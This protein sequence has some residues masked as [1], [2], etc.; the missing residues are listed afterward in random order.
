MLRMCA[1]GGQI[2]LEVVALLDE[3]LLVVGATVAGAL[4]DGAVDHVAQVALERDGLREGTSTNNVSRHGSKTTAMAWY[5]AV[6][7]TRHRYVPGG[8]PEYPV[9]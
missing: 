4:G 7:H 3:V 6:T 1:L 5:S 9:G 2:G 8:Y